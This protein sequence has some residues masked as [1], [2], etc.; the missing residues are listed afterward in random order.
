M[1]RPSAPPGSSN[2]IWQRG[3]DDALATFVLGEFGSTGVCRTT[4]V[5]RDTCRAPFFLQLAI[6]TSVSELDDPE[7][8]TLV[9]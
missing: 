9:F 7:S 3:I 5:C 2:S 6:L 1:L 8:E 4:G